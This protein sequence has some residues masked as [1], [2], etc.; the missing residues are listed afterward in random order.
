MSPARTQDATRGPPCGLAV[1]S[2]AVASRA[3]ARPGARRSAD[4]AGGEGRGGSGLPGAPVGRTVARRVRSLFRSESSPDGVW[5]EFD[6]HCLRFSARAAA[7]FAPPACGPPP[8][9]R[10]VRSRRDDQTGVERSATTS[11]DPSVPRGE[12]RPA[13]SLGPGRGAPRTAAARGGR[14]RGS[15]G[16]VG[17]TTS[18]G[19]F[20][21]YF[22]ANPPRMVC[23]ANL[24]SSACVFRPARRRAS[25]HRR[26]AHLLLAAPSAHAATTRRASSGAT[27]PTA[28]TSAAAPK[29]AL[30][31]GRGSPARGRAARPGPGCSSASSRR[32]ASAR[33]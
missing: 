17:R 2:W 32:S 14:V 6:K 16:S 18:R 30:R 25:R 8:P 11:T 19:G 9:R 12:W 21:R 15:W 4:G 29:P 1:R 24:T 7:R 3:V 33:P 22:G 20:A 28:P 26:A 13:R 27:A 23:G 5:D 10:A 31:P